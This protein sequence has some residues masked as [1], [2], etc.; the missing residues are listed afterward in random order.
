MISLECQY[1]YQIQKSNCDAL[2]STLKPQLSN[3]VFG[4]LDVGKEYANRL[5][6]NAPDRVC[7]GGGGKTLLGQKNEPGL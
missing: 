2:Y 4:D 1:L 6:G 3:S 7:G 5:S